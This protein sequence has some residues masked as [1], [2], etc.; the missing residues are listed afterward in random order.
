MTGQNLAGPGKIT[1][2]GLLL[3]SMPLLAV[4]LAFSNRYSEFGKGT[5]KS[6]S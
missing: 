6:F 1:D 5:D 2:A 4:D 3:E